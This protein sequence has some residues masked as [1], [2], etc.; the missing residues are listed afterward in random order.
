VTAERPCH[1]TLSQMG[2]VIALLTPLLNRGGGIRPLAGDLPGVEVHQEG[3]LIVVL[4][5]P[6]ERPIRCLLPWSVRP[7]PRC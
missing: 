6:H 5:N 2:Q 3:A 1:L 7:P 4:I